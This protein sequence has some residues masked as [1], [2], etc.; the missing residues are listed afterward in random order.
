MF[1][2]FDHITI[3]EKKIENN[4]QMLIRLRESLQTNFVEFRIC[5]NEVRI[6]LFEFDEKINFAN[7]FFEIHDCAFDEIIDE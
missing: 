3:I 4:R 6:A 7:D 1:R 2:R 5:V